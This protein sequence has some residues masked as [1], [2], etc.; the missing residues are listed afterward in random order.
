MDARPYSPTL[1]RSVLAAGLGWPFFEKKHGHI[2]GCRLY[3]PYKQVLVI[4]LEL[5]LRLTT[6]TVLL[7]LSGWLTHLGTLC[8]RQPSNS[9]GT[10]GTQGRVRSGRRYLQ[11]LYLGTLDRIHIQKVQHVH[12][13]YTHGSE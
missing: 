12:I 2:V 3:L 11:V 7:S 5:R 13:R 6:V 1:I 8:K 10:V 4:I 9:V